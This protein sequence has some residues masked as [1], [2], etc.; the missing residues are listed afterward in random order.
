MM[1]TPFTWCHAA[2]LCPRYA[3]CFAVL[4][5]RNTLTQSRGPKSVSRSRE[6]GTYL[7]EDQHRFA[8]MVRESL[9]RADVCFSEH[10][11]GGRGEAWYAFLLETPALETDLFDHRERSSPLTFRSSAET[12]VLCECRRTSK[13]PKIVLD[14]FRDA[15]TYACADAYTMAAIRVTLR[16]VRRSVT[17][18]TSTSGSTKISR[19][20]QSSCVRND[21][22]R[23]GYDD[24]LPCC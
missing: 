9:P 13:K 7:T 3:E 1:E 11:V 21:D 16:A 24:D 19:R 6:S 14:R 10:I 17:Q 20:R 23:K 4:L 22:D 18:S 12:I 5:S 15:F 2:A 8:A